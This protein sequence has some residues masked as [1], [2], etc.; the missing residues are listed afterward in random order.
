MSPPE[1]HEHKLLKLDADGGGWMDRGN[2]LCPFHLSSTGGKN[3]S[4]LAL[5]PEG[6]FFL[7]R[8]APFV[9]GEQMFSF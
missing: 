3:G 4:L 7:L 8:G 6:K 1:K 9:P 2:T 5:A